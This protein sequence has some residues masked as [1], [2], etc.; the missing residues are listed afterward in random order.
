MRVSC[1]CVIL[2]CGRYWIGRGSSIPDRDDGVATELRKAA[3]AGGCA[4]LEPPPWS[5][6]ETR[7]PSAH[8]DVALQLHGTTVGTPI[9]WTP[10]SI[11]EPTGLQRLPG[12]G[13]ARCVRR[14]VALFPWRVSGRAGSLS[15]LLRLCSQGR[16]RHSNTGG[17]VV[18][19]VEELATAAP[20]A[21]A[22]C[23]QGFRPVGFMDRDSIV[24]A[25]QS[26]FARGPRVSAS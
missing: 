4:S 23:R 17:L 8:R 6:R 15:G 22:N 18:K 21:R 13:G 7:S 20:D 9:C 14:R 25:I 26:P 3:P 19:S 10:R 24:A 16:D 12:G 11:R 1:E 2:S 5:G